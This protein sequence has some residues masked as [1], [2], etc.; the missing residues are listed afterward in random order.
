MIHICFPY[1][2][3]QVMWIIDFQF[4]YGSYE[5]WGFHPRH[6]YNDDP[7]GSKWLGLNIGDHSNELISMAMTQE[8]QLEVP[9]AQKRPM[10]LDIPIYTPKIWAEIW[11]N[12]G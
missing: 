5:K 1:G 12:M 8:P 6:I 11:Y 3:P 2:N 10:S 4:S 7:Y 9:T